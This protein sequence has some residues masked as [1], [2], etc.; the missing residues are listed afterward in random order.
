M[1]SIQHR[2]IR[3]TLG[4]IVGAIRGNEMSIRTLRRM[5]DLGALMFFMPWG[6]EREQI[7]IDHIPAEWIIP[8]TADHNK[9]LLYLHGGGY[10][11]GS[12]QTHRAFVGQMAKQAG[13]CGLLIEYRLA[14]E[15]PHPAAVEDAVRA[16]QWLLETGHAPEDIVLAGDSAGGGLTLAT[17]ITL[18]EMGLPQPVCSVLISPW[19][20]LTI[21]QDSVYKYV[22]RSPVIFLREMKAWARNYAGIYPLDHP[23]V[24]PLFADLE[25]LPPMLVQLSDSEVLVDEGRLLVEKARK[26]GVD[27][28]Y[29][30]YKGLI[31]VWHIYWR[32][33]PVARHAINKI[34][35]YIDKFSPS[36]M[37]APEEEEI[38]V[39]AAS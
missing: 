1:P 2:L 19:V 22:D 27:V 4:T 8:K 17:M 33:L 23:T 34:V 37:R 10:A 5:T 13:Y 38:P 12:K 20:D 32:Y 6:V 14:P 24:S 25:G 29:Q 15:D 18:R 28:V 21:S 16:Y 31:H 11:V 36:E 30:E 39:A 35:A 9:V 7:K 26:A 3:T